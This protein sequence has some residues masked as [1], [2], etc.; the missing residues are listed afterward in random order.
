MSTPSAVA[1]ALIAA[2]FL[3]ISSV[4]ERS[5]KQVKTRR[6]RFTPAWRTTARCARPRRGDE[7]VQGSGVDEAAIRRLADSYLRS[8][9]VII[10]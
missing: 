10:A 4:A 1:S 2:L 8:D 5:T 9:R 3:G 6:A 7:L